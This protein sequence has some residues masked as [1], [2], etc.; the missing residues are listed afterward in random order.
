MAVVAFF[1]RI[2]C[3]HQWDTSRSRKGSYVCRLCGARKA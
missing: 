2:F 1:K 3:R